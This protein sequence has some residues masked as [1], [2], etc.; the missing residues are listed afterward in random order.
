[1]QLI[2]LLIKQGD[3][4]VRTLPFKR[5]L[6]LILDKPTP[7]ST[8]SGNSVGKTTVLRLIDFCLGSDGDDI[9]QDPEF[10]SVN[11]DVYDFLHGTVPVSVTLKIEDPVRGT[12]QLSRTFSS[13]PSGKPSFRIDDVA[14]PQAKGYKIAVKQLLFGYGGDKPTLRQLA[15]KFVRSSTILMSRTLRFLGDFATAAEYEALHLFLFGFF[16]VD[17]LEDRV[18]LTAK[19]KNLDRDWEALNRVRGEGQIEQMLILLRREIE[20]IGLSPQLRGEVPAI[21]ARA[22][23]VSTIRANAANRVAEVGRI[24]AEIAS[25]RLTIHELENEYSDIDRLAIESVYREAHNYIPKLQH[26]WEELTDFVQNLRGRKQRFLQSQ[27]EAMEE[28]AKATKQE[29][30]ALQEQERSEIGELVKSEEFVAALD[31]RADLQDKLKSLGSLEQSQRDLQDLKQRIA[32]VDELLSATQ[33]KI[34]DEKAALQQRISIFNKYFSKLSKLLYGEEYLLHFE[35]TAKGSLIFRL[36]AV[37]ANVGAG[38]KASQTAAFDLAYIAFLKEAQISFP[39]FVCHDGMEQI[40]GNQMQALLTEANAIDGQLILATLR[41]K[42]PPLSPQF[43]K[44]NTIL[45]LAQD[46][47]F[48]RI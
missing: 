8:Q 16:S 27:V 13:G 44:E 30:S 25:L 38:K 32:A 37:G 9:W 15:P 26:D 14:Y 33:K 4:V 40:H 12:H 43:L 5:G 21:A 39:E 23:S 42:L 41:D 31:M 36:T 6:N 34:E 10:K 28:R 24:E 20:A 1:M 46:D 7:A 29:L 47:K 45:E 18:T 22:N 48:F 11:Q 35:E 19:K 2:E 17:V 3:V